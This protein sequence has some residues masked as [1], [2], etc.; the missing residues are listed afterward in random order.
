MN[1]QT[2]AHLQALDEKIRP[3]IQKSHY[4]S[5]LR[6]ARE[7]ASAAKAERSLQAYLRAQ[8]KLFAYPVHLLDP[9]AANE[10][11]M[12]TIPLLESVEA[13]REFEPELDVE[14]YDW[15]V[16]NMIA[17]AYDNLADNTGKIHGYNSPG[18]HEAIS[19]GMEVCRTR[20]RPEC[21]ACFKTYASHVMKAADDSDMALH[22]AHESAGAPRDW[23]DKRFYSGL[24]L[25]KIHLKRGE[26]EASLSSLKEGLAHALTPETPFSLAVRGILQLRKLL[27]LMG[28]EGELESVLSECDPNLSVAVLDEVSIDEWPEF[29][30]MRDR[31]TALELACRGETDEALA[32]LRPWDQRLLRDGLL[33]WW[34]DVRLQLLAAL[35]VAGRPIERLAAELREHAANA[36]D[37]ATLATARATAQL[38]VGGQPWAGVRPADSGD[39][40]PSDSGPSSSDSGSSD[41]VTALK[42]EEAQSEAC[43]TGIVPET[44]YQTRLDAVLDGF[45][46]ETAS[47]ERDAG[48]LLEILEI[49]IE[50]ME[51]ARDASIAL[52]QARHL[53]L[54]VEDLEPVASWAGQLVHRYSDNVDVIAGDALLHSMWCLH[55]G[56]ES[57]IEPPDVE[58]RWQRAID[59]DPDRGQLVADAGT[60]AFNVGNL[61][62]AEQQLA[63]AV[64]LD[65]S[66]IR[67]LGMLVQLYDLLDRPSDALAVIDLAIRQGNCQDYESAA[68]FADRVDRH[69]LTLT[70]LERAESRGAA[71]PTGMNYTKA[72]ALL[73]LGRLAEAEAV[74]DTMDPEADPVGVHGL[75]V[76]LRS[77]DGN[78]PS[79]AF[80]DSLQKLTATRWWTEGGPTNVRLPC[81]VWERVTALLPEDHPAREAYA[82]RLLQ[83]GLAPGDLVGGLREGE[84]QPVREFSVALVQVL[85][86]NF[87]DHPGCL[88]EDQAEWEAYM[89]V[90]QVLATNESEAVEYAQQAQARCHEGECLAFGARPEPNRYHDQPGVVGMTSRQP[91]AQVSDDEAEDMR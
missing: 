10:A 20:G 43:E 42:A 78:S 33:G 31:T 34:F 81:L 8:F 27:A 24:N 17:C 91:A 77:H 53:V 88:S 55:K 30:M 19:A 1:E 5:G 2:Q 32:I 13:A 58:R 83:L 39:S 12:E 7:L 57:G 79:E 45:D 72:R 80:V 18:M 52:D 29:E 70:Y 86:D 56:A 6:L 90:W 40:G 3:L 4:R 38:P 60:F 37:W 50:L 36:R 22:Y 28:R 44:P 48:R 62:L 71:H 46:P 47:A 67:A 21:V 65:R 69:E 26:L 64:R 73:G 11:A 15:V 63:R 82:T 9:Q 66:D 35:Q 74:V 61:G 16:H 49:P 87:G 41:P 84:P 54:F 68:Y 85:G 59:L 75:R 89:Q 25:S 51:V 23:G 14:Q 76:L